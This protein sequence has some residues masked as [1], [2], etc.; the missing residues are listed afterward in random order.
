MILSVFFS[1]IQE[2]AKQRDISLT[3]ALN[4]A[5]HMGYSMAEID[6]DA[7]N[8]DPSILPALRE[9]G[10]GISSIYC[11]FSFEQQEQTDRIHALVKLAASSGAKHVMPIPG[12]H[13]AKTEEG[14]ATELDRMLS[15]MKTLTE[16]AVEAGLTV[17]IEDFDSAASP[18]R[19]SRGMRCFLDRIPSLKVTFDTGNFRFS[20]EDELTAFDALKERIAHVHLKDRAL[21]DQF[22]AEALTALCGTALYPA[23]VGSGV[24]PMTEILNRLRGIGYEGILTVEHFGARDQLTCMKCSAEYLLK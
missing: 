22:G 20:G 2:A 8:G 4:A 16:V 23:P 13:H 10:M 12:F 5:R 19:N 9:A 14:R 21:T 17:T 24:I 11:F 7:L 3:D 6:F 18:I 15:G 1:H